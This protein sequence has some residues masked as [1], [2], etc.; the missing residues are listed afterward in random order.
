[1]M[2]LVKEEAPKLVIGSYRKKSTMKLA[3]PG[4]NPQ[5]IQAL[6]TEFNLDYIHFSLPAY[7]EKLKNSDKTFAE[8]FQPIL[9]RKK[10]LLG[11]S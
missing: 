7:D 5:L 1:M 2:R 10:L 6:P 11:T 4:M 3:I 9:N 8:L